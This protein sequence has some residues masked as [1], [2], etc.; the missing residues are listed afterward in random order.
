M[1]MMHQKVG[2]S[3]INVDGVPSPGAPQRFEMDERVLVHII[4]DD[5]SL[6]EAIG[7]LLDTMSVE[8]RLYSSAHQ[9][10]SADR[11]DL[12][13]CVVIDVRLPGGQSGLEFLECIAGLGIK[14]PVIVIT[15][16]GDVAMSVRA[17]KAGAVDFLLKPFR[18][19]DMIDAVVAAIQHDRQMRAAEAKL[20]RIRKN[21]EVLSARERQIMA[22]VAAGLM[23]KQVA[24]KLGIS[25]ATAKIRRGA[26][27]RKMDAQSLADLVRMADQLGLASDCA[28]CDYKLPI[29]G[30]R[31]PLRVC[32]P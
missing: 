10:L 14:L 4:D 23:N 15:G 19:Q 21:F 11:P 18:A 3:T 7:D 22:L 26:M 8:S 6:R 9:F 5:L 1:Q 30:Q 17:M 12:P 31:M 29:S 25:E 28:D 20:A 27:M 13:G 16:Y 24:W 2:R 32:S